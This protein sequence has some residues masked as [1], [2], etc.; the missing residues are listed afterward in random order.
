[1]NAIITGA[2]RGIGLAVCHRLAKAGYHLFISSRSQSDLD[3]LKNQLEQTYSITAH[4]FQANSEDEQEIALFAK[5]ILQHTNSIDV[6]INNV[7]VYHTSSIADLKT[8]E[9]KNL[10]QV[11]FIGAHQLTQFLLPLM[12]HQQHGHIFNINSILGKDLRAD[13]AGYT[14]SKHAL[15]VWSKLLFHELRPFGVKVTE[16]F[17]SSTFTSSWDG[18]SVNSEDLIQANDIA[19]MI[20]QCINMSAGAVMEE[21]VIRTQ[22]KE[23]D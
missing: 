13:A 9:L 21:I 17:P 4:A 15:H 19:E 8:D 11:N 20:Y 16:V 14:I 18:V 5:Y 22:K 12:K 10:L 7:G 3:A 2:T 23:F 6:L 1:M